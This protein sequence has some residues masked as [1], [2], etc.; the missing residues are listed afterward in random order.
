MRNAHPRF[1]CYPSVVCV[2]KETAVTVTP[3]DISRIFRE[4]NEYELCVIGLLDDQNDYHKSSD[5]DHPVTAADGCLHFTFTFERE[6]EYS[7]RFRIK[8]S[9]EVFRVPLYAVNEDLYALRPLKGDLHTHTYYSDG[10]DGFAMTPADYREEGFDFFSLTDHNRMYTSKL[11]SELYDG[12]PLGM[13]IM[14]GEEVH[15]PNSNLHIVHIGGNASVCEKYILNNDEY[16]AEID[17]MEKDFSNI[18]ELYRRRIAMAKWAVQEIHKAGGLAVF[19]HPFWCPNRYN[20]S[21]DF[22]DILFKEIDFDAFELVGGIAPK[23]NNLQLALWQEQAL[24]G[25]VLPI[26]GSSDSHDH[27]FAKGGFAR[28]FTVVFAKENST[29]A[30]LDAIKNGYCVAGELPTTSESEVRFY[31]SQLRLVAFAH[32]LFENYFN[33]TWRLCLGEGILMR[34]FA[35]GEDVAE[36]LTLLAPTVENFY[37]KFYGLLPAPVI[38]GERREILDRALHLQR[39]IGPITKGSALHIYGANG[40]RE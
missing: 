3:R 5:F 38:C 10:A 39:T 33:E 28:R 13:H 30:I 2:G 25:N 6:Q 8:D 17:N 9:K 4:E 24:K 29:E 22:C 40:R 23:Q 16:N 11:A 26:V 7:I 21:Q 27:D 32:F 18:P 12:V 20:I 37:K 1:M 34:R 35:E 19:A 15:T 31:G 36:E 14:S